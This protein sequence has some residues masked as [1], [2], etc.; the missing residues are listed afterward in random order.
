M[1]RLLVR[2]DTVEDWVRLEADFAA[3]SA[4]SNAAAAILAAFQLVEFAPGKASMR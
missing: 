1:T 3:A 2:T 4:D